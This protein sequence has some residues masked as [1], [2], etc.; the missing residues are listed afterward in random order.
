MGRKPLKLD[1][2]VGDNTGIL[3]DYCS[4]S[5]AAD[6]KCTILISVWQRKMKWQATNCWRSTGLDTKWNGIP[7]SRC[8]ILKSILE[9]NFTLS[10][11][12]CTYHFIFH[13]SRNSCI[14]SNKTVANFVRKWHLTTVWQI[15]DKIWKLHF[16]CEVM[17]KFSRDLKGIK[18]FGRVSSWNFSHKSCKG[19]RC[20]NFSNFPAKSL[21]F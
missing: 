10:L 20:A 9:L 17:Q 5:C 18:N 15:F 4:C 19:K 16:L 1:N 13:V 7:R 21:S 2:F 3:I 6:P 8:K 12:W 14:F 11:I